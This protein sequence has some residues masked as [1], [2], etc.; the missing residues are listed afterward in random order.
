VRDACTSVGI[1]TRAS[2]DWLAEYRERSFVGSIDEIVTQLERYEG[3]DRVMLQHL[4]HDDLD[5]I[6][7]MGRL[8][9]ELV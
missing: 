8:G 1:A 9:Q 5:A 6:A 2:K 3:C 7:L 4:L